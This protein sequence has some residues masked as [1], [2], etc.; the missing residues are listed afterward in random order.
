MRLKDQV[1]I[2]TGG[3]RGIGRAIALRLA[4]D[5]A[6]IGVLDLIEENARNVAEEVKQ[7]GSVATAKKVDVTNYAATK[8]AVDEVASEFKMIDIL[9]NNVG[10]DQSKFFVDT[11]ETFWDRFI[12]VDYKTFLIATHVTIPYMMKQNKGKIVSIGSDAG[13]VGNIGEP[14]Y[15]GAKGAIIATTKALARE[16]ARYNINVNCVCPGPI[17]TDLLAGLA[18]DERGK[19]IMEAT[20]KAIPLKRI[21][22]PEDVADVVAFFVSDDARYVTGQVLS[23]DGGLTMIG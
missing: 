15:C 6:K 7:L 18:S 17:E 19:K 1:A 2:V 13:R 23:V 4:K 12:T 14:I 5:G 3:G 16:L 20:A 10:I 11:D 9:V 22:Q 8:K 21:G